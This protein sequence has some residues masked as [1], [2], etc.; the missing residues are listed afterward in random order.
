MYKCLNFFFFFCLFQFLD[1][2]KVTIIYTKE[3][4]KFGCRLHVYEKKKKK[5]KRDLSV[6]FLA[7]CWNL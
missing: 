6:L 4:V 3:N 7:T 2:V 5:K 1:V